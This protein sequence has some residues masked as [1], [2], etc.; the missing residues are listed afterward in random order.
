M[1]REGFVVLRFVAGHVFQAVW[2]IIFGQGSAQNANI[3]LRSLMTVSS[4]MESGNYDAADDEEWN[5]Q[6]DDRVVSQQL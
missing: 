5:G 4:D 3:Q 1:R 6:P 2:V